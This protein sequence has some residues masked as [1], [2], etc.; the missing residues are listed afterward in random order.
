[1]QFCFFS[2][3]HS[4]VGLRVRVCSWIEL[5]FCFILVY[6]FSSLLLTAFMYFFSCCASSLA[7]WNRLAKMTESLIDKQ[8]AM[9]FWCFNKVSQ[10]SKDSAWRR[11]CSYT[12][13]T[14]ARG[15]V[16]GRVPRGSPRRRWMVTELW[17]G[18]R[19][20]THI[21]L[22]WGSSRFCARSLVLQVLPVW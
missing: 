10:L 20:G 22:A 18:G 15:G 5:V 19:S 17:C 21:F 12:S 13:R 7:S 11:V 3:R 2:F 16:S 14:W 8:K 1:M 4:I 9:L 6:H